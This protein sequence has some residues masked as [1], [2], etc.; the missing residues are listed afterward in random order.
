MKASEMEMADGS[1]EFPVSMQILRNLTRTLRRHLPDG[2]VVC[3]H[4][5]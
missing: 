3:E 1:N 5:L 4:A 2:R